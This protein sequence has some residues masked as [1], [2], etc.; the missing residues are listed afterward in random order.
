MEGDKL[1]AFISFLKIRLFWVSR[2]TPTTSTQYRD[3]GPLAPRHKKDGAVVIARARKRR[4]LVTGSCVIRETTLYFTYDPETRGGR[5][6]RGRFGQVC[7]SLPTAMND[8]R[9]ARTGGCSRYLFT[10]ASA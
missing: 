8:E 2:A 3:A 5:S 6:G 9:A 1:S 10:L 4:R 7:K